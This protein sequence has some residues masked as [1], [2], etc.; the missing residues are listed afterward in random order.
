MANMAHAGDFMNLM[1]YT[2]PHTG[3]TVIKSRFSTDGRYHI[4]LAYNEEKGEYVTWERNP[5]NDEEMG[6]INF[7]YGHY[8]QHDT[9][10]YSW[11][12]TKE[13]AEYIALEDYVTR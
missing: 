2:N 5:R 8:F 6:R 1:G 7:Y 3:H 11:G 12:H 13:E 4:V 9:D 10:E